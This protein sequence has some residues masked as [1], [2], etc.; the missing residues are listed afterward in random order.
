VV[1]IDQRV[2]IAASSEVV[3]SYL[4]NPAMM[5]R[6]HAGCKQISILSTRPTGISA[7]RRI[8]DARGRSSVEEITHWLENLGYEYNMVEGRFRSYRARFRLQ[9]V[10][11]GTVVNWTVEYRLRGMLPGLRNLVRVRR[12]TNRQM[13]DSLKR[14]RKLV[15]SSGMRLDIEKQ[16]RFAMRAAPSVEA[17]AARAAEEVARAKRAAETTEVAENP[18]AAPAFPNQATMPSAAVAQARLSAVLRSS[19]AAPTP[20]PTIANA[21]L[22]QTPPKK[23]TTGSM[24][25][26]ENREPSFVSK[27]STGEI[28]IIPPKE[29][30]P[31]LVDTK[32]RKPKGLAE[33]IAA[34]EPSAPKQDTG[35]YDPS[36][37]TV[38]VSLVAPPPAPTPETQTMEVFSTP[39]PTG[40]PTP[41]P[42]PTPARTP[43]NLPELQPT[44]RAISLAHLSREMPMVQMPT[45]SLEKTT[46]PETQPVQDANAP[47]DA[48][49]DGP[50][51]GDTG[52]MSIWEVFGVVP[53]S[54]RTRTDLEQ[55][56]AEL[57]TPPE[58]N[59][60][61]TSSQVMAAMFEDLPE[62]EP[63]SKAKAKKKAPSRRAHPPVRSPKV[64]ASVAKARM[65]ARANIKACR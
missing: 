36:A 13:V 43:P 22:A 42:A 57:K 61:V 24:P 62:P 23:K 40:T 18:P 49:D 14:L 65:G 48:V 2:L 53:P 63:K 46:A 45:E 37:L 59:D 50:H 3:W 8:T 6:W 28:P 20:E 51:T 10:P 12:R 16:A 38:P 55:I 35:Q 26:V 5:P 7:R 15:E 41:R 58:A 32:P 21:A 19:E 30:D 34:Q 52:Q 9:A 54:E 47:S 31:T 64:N 33:A 17:R 1:L 56:I 27:I 29:K 60:G 44:P 39:T 25:V 4:T 11:E